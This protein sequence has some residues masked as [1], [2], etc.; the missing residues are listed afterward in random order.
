MSGCGRGKGA[1]VGRAWKEV[2]GSGGW[3]PVGVSGLGGPLREFEF[4]SKFNG[5]TLQG[6][7]KAIERERE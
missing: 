1:T 5:K 7:L 3:L 6:V 2:V 4:Y